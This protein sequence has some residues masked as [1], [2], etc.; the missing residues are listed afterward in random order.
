METLLGITTTINL[1]ATEIKKLLMVQAFYLNNEM[2]DFSAKPSD[3][4][5]RLD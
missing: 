5:M 4:L 1:S 3:N 2:D